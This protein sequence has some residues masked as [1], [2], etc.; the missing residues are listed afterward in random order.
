MGR[1]EEGVNTWVAPGEYWAV[2]GTSVRVGVVLHF[3][4]QNPRES[5]S[6]MKN[7]HFIFGRENWFFLYGISYCVELTLGRTYSL[8]WLM[9]G[10][11]GF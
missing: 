3:E 6:E 7:L 11:I 9:I 8:W 4:E 10:C 5:S 1:G 2:A